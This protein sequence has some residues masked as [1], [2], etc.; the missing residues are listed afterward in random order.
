VSCLADLERFLER[1]FSV[2]RPVGSWFGLRPS[3]VWVWKTCLEALACSDLLVAVMPVPSPGVAAE[4][5]VGKLIGKRVY[6]FCSKALLGS[7]LVQFTSDFACA[8]MFEMFNRL[9][10]DYETAETPS[11]PSRVDQADS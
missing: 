3:P 8:D 5:M 9:E 1:K 11:A 6:T 10:V 2:F 4:M 7:S